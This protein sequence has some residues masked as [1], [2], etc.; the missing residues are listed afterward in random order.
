MSRSVNVQ[1]AKKNHLG[2]L[3]NLNNWCR[4]DPKSQTAFDN[5]ICNIMCIIF[6][7]LRNDFLQCRLEMRF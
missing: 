5:S 7:D 4:F 1:Y 3:K 6:T 2:K